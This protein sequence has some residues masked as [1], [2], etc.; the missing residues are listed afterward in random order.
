MKR[1][2]VIAASLAFSATAAA[3]MYK[4]KDKDGHTRY[5]DVPP[6]GADATP[7]RGPS[8]SAPYAAPAPDDAKP[9]DAKPDAKADAKNEKPLTPEQAFRKRQQERAAADE[10]AQQ[11]RQR[12]EAKR[13]NCETAQTQ[14]RVLQSGQ[15]VSSVNAAGERVYLDDDQRAAEMNRAQKA[16]ADWC[17]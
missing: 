9:D 10:K 5:G 3:Q 11:E 2:I 1:L 15:R 8:R 14:L 16:V 12:A 7:M 4:W 17:N 6:P 13:S